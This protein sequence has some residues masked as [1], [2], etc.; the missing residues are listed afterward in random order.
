MV[1]RLGKEETGEQV[2]LSEDV[3][4]VSVWCEDAVVDFGSAELDC[5]D[6]AVG[7]ASTPAASA[8]AGAVAPEAVAADAAGAPA[9]GAGGV[10]D[11]APLD[12][13]APDEV[14]TT[15][16]VFGDAGANDVRLPGEEEPSASG[17]LAVAALT[18]FAAM[19][20]CLL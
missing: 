4:Y 10:V 12:E 17:S 7:P 3:N 15:G 16:D 14:P 2:L 8:P 1:V 11:G 6:A 9:A 20:A 13:N 18:G 19:V 5:D